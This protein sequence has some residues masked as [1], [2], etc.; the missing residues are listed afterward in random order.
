MTKPNTAAAWQQGTDVGI[1]V[2]VRPGARQDAL[3]ELRADSVRLD[4]KA[5]PEK[6]EANEGVVKFFARLFKKPLSDVSIRFGHTSRKKVV[7]I[8]NAV[9]SEILSLLT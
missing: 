6:G 2:T 1:N 4:V 9:L 7:L 3:R 5:P 8:H